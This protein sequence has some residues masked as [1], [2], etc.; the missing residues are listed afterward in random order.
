[1]LQWGCCCSLTAL[2]CRRRQSVRILLFC[3]SRRRA[4]KAASR[5]RCGAYT[6]H[7]VLQ[8]GP[9]LLFPDRS[10][11]QWPPSR[12]VLGRRRRLPRRRNRYRGGIGQRLAPTQPAAACGAFQDVHDGSGKQRAKQERRAQQPQHAGSLQKPSVSSY[13]T[14]Q[15]SRLTTDALSC[16][17]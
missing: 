4:A 6:D 12:D 5:Q 15:G 14:R 3:L 7:A 13:L 1:M 10:H 2:I 11:L 16:V 9:R 8:A 17:D